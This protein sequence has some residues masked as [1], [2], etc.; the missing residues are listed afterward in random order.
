[1]PG[2]GVD[3]VPDA[4]VAGAGPTEAMVAQRLRDAAVA[5]A[6]PPA[7]PAGAQ[8]IQRW[9][10]GDAGHLHR[11]ADLRTAPVSS[12]R[13]LAGNAVV[14]AKRA[15][16]RLLYPLIDLQ[17]GINAANAR[18]VTFLLEQLAAQAGRIEELQREVTELR[19]ERER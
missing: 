7:Q 17:S 14:A 11:A 2:E 18:V 4:Q 15:A 8:T 16:R 13:P 9:L 5:V 6:T 12:H 10:D 1:M 3:A 19:A